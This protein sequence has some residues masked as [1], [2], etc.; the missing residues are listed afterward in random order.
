MKYICD[1]A[2]AAW[3]F[4]ADLPASGVRRDRAR[5][6]GRIAWCWTLARSRKRSTLA[7]PVA[8]GGLVSQWQFTERHDRAQKQHHA[9]LSPGDDMGSK[10]IEDYNLST[11]I[12]KD[13]EKSLEGGVRSM[14]TACPTSTRT[15]SSV[16]S[17]GFS[18]STTQRSGPS[19]MVELVTCHNVRIQDSPSSTHRVD[20]PPAGL[21]CVK[22]HAV[23]IVN[24]RQG[25]ST[26][27]IDVDSSRNVQISDCYIERATIDRHQR[28]RRLGGRRCR[29]RHHCHN[30]VLAARG[31]TSS[32]DGE[33]RRF[34]EHWSATA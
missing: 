28:P 12:R 4:A 19:P 33:P 11:D 15:L 8:A 14:A 24:H 10:K 7:P 9:A 16:R 18:S 31:T 34:Q 1:S 30:C 20:H 21:R 32:W 29:R 26:D 22:I 17:S 6:E 2:T 23:S 13:A 27:G 25:P 3:T 5:R